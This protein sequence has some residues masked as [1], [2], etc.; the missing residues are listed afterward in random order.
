MESQT[1]PL[2]YATPPA[3][4]PDRSPVRIEESSDELLVTI[5][6]RQLWSLLFGRGLGLA[7]SIGLFLIVAVFCFHIR[8]LRSDEPDVPVLAV[9]LCVT[10]WF[11]WYSLAA[12]LRAARFAHV[13]ATIRASRSGLMISNPA[14]DRQPMRH[15]RR[16]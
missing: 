7:V 13:P 9:A 6:P 16:E 1:P 5:P 12:F 15:W 11:I 3:Q 8:R 4:F 10:A 2:E 14:E